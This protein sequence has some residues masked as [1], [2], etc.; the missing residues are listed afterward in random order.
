MRTKQLTLRKFLLNGSPMFVAV[1]M[2]ICNSVA[3]ESKP[4]D[5]AA[6]QII[7]SDAKSVED[8]KYFA[9]EETYQRA[10]SAGSKITPG[11]QDVRDVL[12][13]IACR[14]E[15]SGNT[16]K[17]RQVLKQ[18]L[19][20]TREHWPNDGVAIGRI[21]SILALIDSLY[22]NSTSAAAY[23]KQAS[24]AYA[25]SV[26][27]PDTELTMVL[28]RLMFWGFF[29]PITFEE[30]T[31]SSDRLKQLVAKRFAQLNKSTS[32]DQSEVYEL[33]PISLAINSGKSQP[34]DRDLIESTVAVLK[35]I[36]I[37]NKTGT[38]NDFLLGLLLAQKGDVTNAEEKL[39]RDTSVIQSKSAAK[40][41]IDWNAIRDLPKGWPQAATKTQIDNFLQK[42]PDIFGPKDVCLIPVYMSIGSIDPDK[43]E[44][45]REAYT[46]ALGIASNW[47]DANQDSI[48]TARGLL[49]LAWLQDHAQQYDKA[50][51]SIKRALPIY[52]KNY[53]PES[54]QV[55]YVLNS[56]ANNNA[57]LKKY[58]EADEAVKRAVAI[59]TKVTSQSSPLLV[60]AVTEIPILI[61]LADYY[62]KTGQKDKSKDALDQM[63]KI[64]QQKPVE[65]VASAVSYVPYVG[66]V[67]KKPAAPEPSLGE[68]EI[69][70]QDLDKKLISDPTDS[71]I[72]TSW[73]DTQTKLA[74]AYTKTNQF[75]KAEQLFQRIFQVL[76][77]WHESDSYLS[78]RPLEA[79]SQL[80]KLTGRS[81]EADSAYSKMIN[82][83]EKPKR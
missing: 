29:G 32:I 37:E 74:S 44:I 50:A 58:T 55:A 83:I 17:A 81:A 26:G 54:L 77:E 68:L 70:T 73:V 46:R 76:N 47:I 63:K 71:T 60:S 18:T 52:E 9:A 15:S 16:Q 2:L 67:D 59:V 10:L 79:Y 82:I 41:H 21:A 27:L 51:V 3:V 43:G 31:G 65:T 6:S 1:S 49:L 4:D 7:P 56:Y 72:R 30:W 57:N 12:I 40:E 53:G 78:V 66:T 20:S 19:A 42:A 11:T 38:A 48:E 22:G 28:S 62:E 61:D 69:L 13:D 35:K 36:E 8:K 24:Q 75:G 64:A 45:E 5:I 33:V 14:Y 23:R 34:I 39:T 80:L 25:G